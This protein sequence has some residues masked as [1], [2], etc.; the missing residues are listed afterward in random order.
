MFRKLQENIQVERTD[1]EG[2][3]F[4][5]DD[6]GQGSPP[7]AISVGVHFASLAR[8]PFCNSAFCTA[9]VFFITLI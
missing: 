5:E 3:L 8:R 6:R 4:V 7:V 2:V 9:A 1:T